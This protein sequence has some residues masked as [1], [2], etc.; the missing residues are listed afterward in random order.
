MRLLSTRIAGEFA[1]LIVAPLDA[2]QTRR[3][4]IGQ[5]LLDAGA[6]GAVFDRAERPDA[7]F[8]ALFDATL[9]ERSVQQTH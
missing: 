4:E 9:L 5:G 7:D 6:S 1:D 2:A 3:W 8:L